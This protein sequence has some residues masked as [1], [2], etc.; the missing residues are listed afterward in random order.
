M[1][2][3]PAT[4]IF[5]PSLLVAMPMP[6]DQEGSTSRY[7]EAMVQGSTS[8]GTTTALAFLNRLLLLWMQWWWRRRG[9][10]D[11]ARRSSSPPPMSTTTP[12][13]SAIQCLAVFERSTD[14]S[15]IE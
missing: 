10:R 13:A 2:L 4:L 8:A 15:F 5:L 7:Q 14:L 12:T 11:T 3:L 1:N 6:L 9:T